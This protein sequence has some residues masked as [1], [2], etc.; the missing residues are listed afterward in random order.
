MQ[1][2][3]FALHVECFTHWMPYTLDALHIECIVMQ[4]DWHPM[5]YTRYQIITKNKIFISYYYL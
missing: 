3:T 1:F 2:Q 5:E 4:I